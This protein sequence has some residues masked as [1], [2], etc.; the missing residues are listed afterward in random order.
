MKFES[1]QWKIHLLFDKK[2]GEKMAKSLHKVDEINLTV[3]K[4]CLKKT[5][6]RIIKEIYNKFRKFM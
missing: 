2:L 1:I 6:V 3:Q 5:N 4:T